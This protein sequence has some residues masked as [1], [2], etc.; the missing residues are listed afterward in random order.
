MRKESSAL[1]AFRT[2]SLSFLFFWDYVNRVVNY[3]NAF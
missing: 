3:Y 1:N 2:T